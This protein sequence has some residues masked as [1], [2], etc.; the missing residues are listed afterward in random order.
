MR[1]QAWVELWDLKQVRSKEAGMKPVKIDK[2]GENKWM[3]N[4]VR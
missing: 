1:E 2:V 4:G 3:N